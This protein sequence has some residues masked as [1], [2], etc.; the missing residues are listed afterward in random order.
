MKAL[1]FLQP[2]AHAVL[3]LGKVID[4]RS[5]KDGKMPP[6]C[7]YRGPLL[8]HASAG[9]TN[10]YYRMSA[11]WIEENIGVAMPPQISTRP[12]PGGV[13]PMWRRGGIVGRCN[14]IGHVE[15]TGA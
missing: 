11:S 9:E 4:N 13:V 8:I 6:L 10:R 15:P 14:V 7:K 1:A 2:W 5:R 12:S 3:Y